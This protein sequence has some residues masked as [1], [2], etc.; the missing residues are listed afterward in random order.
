MK[1]KII[2]LKE[3]VNQ[4][5]NNIEQYH[6][7]SFDEANTKVSFIEKFFELLD[8]DMR[9]FSGYSESYKDVVLEDKVLI[10]GKPK[11]PDYSFRIGGNKKFFV[12]A[13]KP[14]VNIKEDIDPAFQLRRYAYSAKLP[15][16]I[17]TDF[18]E[19]AVYDTRIKPNK[20]DKAD[21]ARIFYCRFNEYEENFD[22]I[23]KTFSKN[24]ILKGSFD[25]YVIENK[26]KKGTSEVD[27]E[28]LRLIGNWREDL[29]KNIALRNKN[30][31][32]EQLNFAVQ[33]IIDKI[34]FLRIAEDRSIEEYNN[35]HNIAQN[36]NIYNELNKYFQDANKKYDSELFIAEEWF[37][38][39]K[40]DD[41]IFED[42]IKDLYFP[43]SPFVFD[44][45][46]VE[47][48]GNIYEQFLGKTIRLTSGHQAKIEDK[49]EV[50]KAGGVY[51]TPQY[52]VDYIVENTVGEKLKNKKPEDIENLKIL[53]PACGSGSFL[54]GAYDYLIQWHIDFYTKKNNLEKSLK[55][56]KIILI[57]KGNFKLPIEEKQKILKNNIFGV[58]ID[59]Q[60]VEVTKL[61][62]LL[63]LM[64]GETQESS[65][66][67]I[68]IKNKKLLPD[69]STN[70]KCGNSLIG[71]DFYENKNM[72]L[73]GESE[74]RKI[75]VF[76]WQKEFKDIFERGGFD[77][78]I[79]NPPYVKEYTSKESFEALKQSS[80]K[81]YYQGKMDLWY[82]FACFSID[83]LK[84]DGLHSFI[85]TNNWITSAGASILRNTV[86]ENTRIIKFIDF[87]DFKVF[88]NASI[89]TMIYVLEKKKINA[90]YKVKYT[91][92]LNKNILVSDLIDRLN[93]KINKSIE[94]ESDNDYEWFYAEI[95]PSGLRDK[96]LS[97]INQGLQVILKKI[98]LKSN[99]LLKEK[100]VTNGLQVQQENVNKGHIKILGK[101]FKVGEGIFIVS[102]DER[103]KMQ[104]KENELSI[105]KPLFTTNEIDRYF[106]AN[107]NKHWVIYTSSKFQDPKN[108]I[109]FPNIKK[110]LD[111]YLR[112]INTD[113][114]PYGIH[115]TRNEDFF[116]DEKI[117]SI[118]K[119]S[120]P[121][122]SFADFDTYVNQ[123]F[124]V[125][126]PQNI[127]LKYL[128]SILNSKLIYFWLYFKGKKQGDNLQIDKGP[129]LE[130]P[131]IKT[132]DKKTENKLVELV[133]QMLLTQKQ[134]HSAKTESDK[135]TYQQKIDIIDKQIDKV[136]YGLYG[137]NETDV[138][139][140]EKSFKK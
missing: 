121:K 91:K 116:R 101:D 54:L 90:P 84:K 76:D 137:L 59:K 53:D 110:H 66:Q 67:L 12:E 7:V 30:I 80:L 9:N 28:F 113:F 140:I 25:R 36:S 63:K 65:V 74:M 11:A 127:N 119:C 21:V 120:F 5:S 16:S 75:N 40:I 8:W 23:Y 27:K 71:P 35:L 3:L 118:R 64:E 15:L 104:L 49:P 31:D 138:E 61:S 125:I 93:I 52:I 55:K 134:F 135:K 42:I 72:S 48:I 29:A 20:N 46:P 88:E 68:K 33:K 24:E 32:I 78:V 44:M 79:G 128:T 38:D 115:R 114:K 47:I 37:L 70:I 73:F 108:I 102:N 100:D 41:Q 94:K 51:Y 130:L 45:I 62:L 18:E 112:V 4:F 122:F 117:M 89:Q 1:E 107:K 81:K 97:F 50:K 19:F 58:D 69:L 17:L 56:E 129:L 99:F 131:L 82:A 139:V 136:V 124:Y 10:E 103:E 2:K 85:A 111:K 95:N 105:L 133:N 34:L 109:P 14:M 92:V 43:I 39:L 13:K 57:S 132:A 77:C 126:K 60:A 96:S 86:L 22:F 83:L 6:R 106:V 123:V 98:I 87:A 26:N